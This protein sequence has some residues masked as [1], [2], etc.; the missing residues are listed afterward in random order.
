MVH[1]P[2][3]PHLQPVFADAALHVPLPITEALAGEV[4]SLPLWPTMTETQLDYIA[5]A[6]RKALSHPAAEN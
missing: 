4:L 2:R 5:A 1:Y 6:V 3:P